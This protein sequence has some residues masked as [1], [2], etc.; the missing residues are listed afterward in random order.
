MRAARQLP[1]PQRLA[2]RKIL[3]RARSVTDDRF[4]NLHDTVF[5]LD[6]EEWLALAYA[7][8]GVSTK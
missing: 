1:E 6:R 2:L 4:G 3:E 5:Y 8:E 7:F